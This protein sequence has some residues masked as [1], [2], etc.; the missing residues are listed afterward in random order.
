MLNSWG[1][2]PTYYLRSSRCLVQALMLCG[3]APGTFYRWQTVICDRKC[4]FYKAASSLRGVRQW[5]ALPGLHL[6][7]VAT[8]QALRDQTKKTIDS[9][10][11]DA[12]LNDWLR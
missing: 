2:A 7:P 8:G 5:W 10:L 9:L 4:F 6:R 11:S 12:E 3:G 1:Q